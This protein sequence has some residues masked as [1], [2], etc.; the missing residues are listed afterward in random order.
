MV[1]HTTKWKT[2]KTNFANV[3]KNLKVAKTFATELCY[4]AAIGLT[5]PIIF[6]AMITSD[7]GIDTILLLDRVLVL[8]YC[9]VLVLL[10][11]ALTYK[12][13]EIFYIF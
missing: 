9:V 12:I 6:G 11:Q 10:L 4:G 8:L 13:K 1:N 5:S 7:A 3:A 2:F